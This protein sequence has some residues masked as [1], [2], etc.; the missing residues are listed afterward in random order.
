LYPSA[1]T[2]AEGSGPRRPRA[3]S[4]TVRVRYSDTDAQGH[5]YFANYLIYADEVA[6]SYMEALGLPALTPQRAPCFIYTVNVRCDYLGE[7]AAGDTLRVDVGYVRLGR[8]S[9]ELAFFLARDGGATAPLA[10][11][12]LTQVFVDKQSRRPCGLPPAYRAAILQ[13]Q[14][15]L[16]AAEPASL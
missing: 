7:C 12:S 2:V 4:E 1:I 5:L 3:F 14:P 15:E 10:T 9:A 8:S 11:G 6:G 13:W 16:A